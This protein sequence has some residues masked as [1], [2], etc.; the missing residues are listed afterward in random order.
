M[1]LQHIQKLSQFSKEFKPSQRKIQYK[2]QS[3]MRGR[4]RN[5]LIIKYLPSWYKAFPSSIQVL[6]SRHSFA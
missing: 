6:R 4:N 5:V 2:E 1:L 3:S